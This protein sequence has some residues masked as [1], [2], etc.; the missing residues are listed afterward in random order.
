MAVDPMAI[1]SKNPRVPKKNIINYDFFS[2][3]LQYLFYKRLIVCIL[4]RIFGCTWKP[5][6]FRHQ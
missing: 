3:P 1:E 5:L 6:S 4:F 2:L